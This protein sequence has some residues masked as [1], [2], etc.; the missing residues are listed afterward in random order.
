MSQIYT[1]TDEYFEYLEGLGLKISNVYQEMTE[2]LDEL[3]KETQDVFVEHMAQTIDNC[4]ERLRE[5]SELKAQNKNYTSEIQ[6]T[7][8]I[9]D[10]MNQ[11]IH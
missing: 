1:Q 10:E 3:W 7:F 4:K 9:M 5:L 2:K 6:E 8:E 11:I